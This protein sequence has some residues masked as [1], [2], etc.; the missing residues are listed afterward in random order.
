MALDDETKAL[1][2]LSSLPN[3]WET[4]VMSLSNSAPDG[5]L[6]MSSVKDALFNE[7][8]RRKDIGAVCAEQTRALVTENRGSNRG[9]LRS[10]DT[11]TDTDT[12]TDTDTGHGNFEK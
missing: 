12:D 7:E 6:A 3:S 10:T 8:S 11:N 1:L 2:L 9:R 4:L 5:K